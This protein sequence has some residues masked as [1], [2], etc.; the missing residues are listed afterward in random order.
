MPRDLHRETRLFFF[1]FPSS[2]VF[3]SLSSFHA[4]LLLLFFSPLLR[5]FFFFTFEVSR[6]AAGCTETVFR[7]VVGSIEFRIFS[8]RSCLTIVASRFSANHSIHAYRFSCRF[9]AVFVPFSC[10]FRR[11]IFVRRADTRCISRNAY[12]IIRRFMRSDSPPVFFLDASFP[13]YKRSILWRS[14]R[15]KQ[16]RTRVK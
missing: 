16:K 15:V 12:R 14:K 8:Q 10:R 7:A 6:I 5:P 9:R 3:F 11:A 13:S 1:S 4:L 2:S